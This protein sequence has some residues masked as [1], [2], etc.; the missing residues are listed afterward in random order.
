MTDVELLRLRL[1]CDASAPR[2]A[3]DAL[4]RVCELGPVRAAALLIVSELASNAV[5][6]S[7]SSPGDE[8]EVLAVRLP[9]GVRIAVHDRGRSGRVPARRERAPLEPGGMGLRMVESVARRWGSERGTGLSVWA[10]LAL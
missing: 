3:R 6:H 2:R 4:A 5:L 10:D 8:L 7:G 9:D 1:P